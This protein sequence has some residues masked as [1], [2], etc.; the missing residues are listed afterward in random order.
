MEKIIHQIWVG[1]YR[2]PKR[3][4]NYVELMR[5]MNNDWNYIL[6]TDESVKKLNMPENIKK[7]YDYYY[8]VGHFVHASDVLRLFLVYEFGGIYLDID[9]EPRNKI[10]TI[11]PLEDY[12]A[13][14]CY[15]HD[16]G[17]TPHTLPNNVFGSKKNGKLFT[18]IINNIRE[19]NMNGPYEFANISKRYLEL[20]IKD[21]EI[22]GENGLLETLDKNNIFYYSYIDFHE[23][24][25][26]HQALYSHSPVNVIK[27]KNNDYE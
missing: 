24:I 7:S 23:N 25:C 22:L 9:F 16:C 18:Y 1:T 4:S 12:D 17:P 26:N 27:F 2:I 3:E 19:G 8:K 10:S 15:H 14:I 21:T 11:L 13:F 5:S 6:W 20:D